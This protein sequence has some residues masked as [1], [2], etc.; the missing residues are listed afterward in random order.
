[1]IRVEFCL[2]DQNQGEVLP[3]QR[4]CGGKRT[5]MRAPLKLVYRNIRLGSLNFLLNAVVFYGTILALTWYFELPDDISS[6]II[7]NLLALTPSLLAFLFPPKNWK[8]VRNIKELIGYASFFTLIMLFLL[9]NKFD[10]RLL[11]NSAGMIIFALPWGVWVWLLLGRS[12]FLLSGLVLAFIAMLIY[13]IVA[14]IDIG[15]SQ[16]LLLF[17]LLI[18]AVGGIVWA[19]FARLIWN[20]AKQRKFRRLGGPGWQ[21]AAMGFLFIPAILVAITF[22]VMLGLDSIWS[23]TSL[24]LVGVLLSAVISDP[25]RRFLLEWGNL[26]TN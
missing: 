21:V 19:P 22:P 24:T 1:M 15:G 3:F 5:I 23:A 7:L 11:S 12:W 9:G 10:W 26:S 20:N 25:L 2:V 14:I 6:R 16:E 4:R 8:S 17:P 13:W 18:T